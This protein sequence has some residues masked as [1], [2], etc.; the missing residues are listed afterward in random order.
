[1]TASTNAY[2]ALRTTSTLEASGTSVSRARRNHVLCSSPGDRIVYG[3]WPFYRLG[4]IQEPFSVFMSLGNLYVNLRG[5]AELRR[6]IREENKMRM[7]LEIAG[8]CQVNT[9]I[10]ST[11]FHTRGE[12]SLPQRLELLHVPC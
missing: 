7:W 10:W 9:W 8:W 12:C 3:K 2:T 4:P 5:I 1:M 6:R 11:V